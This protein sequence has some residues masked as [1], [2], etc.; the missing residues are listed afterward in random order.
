MACTYTKKGISISPSMCGL[1]PRLHPQTHLGWS[2]G[3]EAM[4]DYSWML[5]LPPQMGGGGRMWGREM[6]ERGGAAR[7]R[8]EEAGERSSY[9]GS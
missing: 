1:I 5:L 6:G 8:G 7:R 4:F 9:E 3:N 2:L